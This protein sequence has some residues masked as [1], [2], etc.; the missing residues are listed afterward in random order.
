MCLRCMYALVCI[1][2]CVLIVYVLVLSTTL[3]RKTSKRKEQNTCYLR[4]INNDRDVLYY[5][6]DWYRTPH[7]SHMIFSIVIRN[8]CKVIFV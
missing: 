4:Y 3:P 6:D 1:D 2:I 8:G 5:C 7:T